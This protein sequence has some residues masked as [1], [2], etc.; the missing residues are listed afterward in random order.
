MISTWLVLEASKQATVQ[1]HSPPA[2][3]YAKLDSVA[4]ELPNSS[5]NMLGNETL[6]AVHLSTCCSSRSRAPRFA[7]EPKS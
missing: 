1:A 4:A 7:E 6:A 5:L 3:Y 2:A